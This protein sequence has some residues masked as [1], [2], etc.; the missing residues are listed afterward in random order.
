MRPTPHVVVVCPDKVIQS[1]AHRC[2]H[3]FNCSTDHCSTLR[4][5]EIIGTENFPSFLETSKKPRLQA[6][7]PSHV[8]FLVKSDKAQRLRGK[9][10]SPPQ[11][12][13]FSEDP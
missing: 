10:G 1:L 2:I 8:I 12:T 13:D 5:L 6:F 11:S 7:Q 3:D 4:R 9:S